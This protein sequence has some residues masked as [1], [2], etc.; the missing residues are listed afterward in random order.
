MHDGIEYAWG[1]RGTHK[2][3]KYTCEW[4]WQDFARKTLPPSLSPS[5]NTE[6][7]SFLKSETCEALTREN[8]HFWLQRLI[9]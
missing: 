6:D 3:Q 1:L 9:S 4:A 2:R 8:H 5:N 7:Y